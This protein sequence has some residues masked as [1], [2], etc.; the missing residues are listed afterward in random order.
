MQLDLTQHTKDI[1]VGE[2]R[3]VAELEEGHPQLDGLANR[4]GETVIFLL[5][6]MWPMNTHGKL[7]SVGPSPF[8]PETQ[9]IADVP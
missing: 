9:V 3:L 8:G 7:V 2:G 6:E 4:V 5:P 1:S